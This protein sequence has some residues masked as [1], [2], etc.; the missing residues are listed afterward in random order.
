M[1]ELRQLVERHALLTGS[2][3]AWDVLAQWDAHHPRFWKVVP[4]AQP[5]LSASD[6]PAQ[7]IRRRT[8]AVDARPEVTSD[9]AAE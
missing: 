7:G 8:A 1:T 4:R 5:D 3:R 2:A 6:S 9:A